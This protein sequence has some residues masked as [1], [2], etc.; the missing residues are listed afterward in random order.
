MRYTHKG[1]DCLSYIILNGVKNTDIYGLMIQTLPPISKPLMR[2]AIETI[3]GRDGDIITKLGYSAYDKPVLVGLYGNFDIDQVIE[4]F[5]NNSE[6]TVTFSDEPDKYYNY[7]IINQIDF[8][9][10]IRL[11]QATV[12]LHVQ[13]FKYSLIEGNKELYL[14]ADRLVSVVNT[15]NIYSKP[16]LT[17]RGNGNVTVSLNGSQVFSI[18]FSTSGVE[19]ITIDTEKM[20]AYDDTRLRNRAVVGDYNNFH[21]AVGRNAVKFGGSGTVSQVLIEKYSRW[22]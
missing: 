6:G 2:T 10:L 11:R 21:F 20:E 19:T 1:G 8:E 18:A 9:R 4:Y 3:D 7:Q 5:N 16:V 15:G 12:T 22:V 14:P 17:I 13:P